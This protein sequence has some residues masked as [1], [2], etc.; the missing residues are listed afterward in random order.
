MN[1]GSRSKKLIRKSDRK[2]GM[3]DNRFEHVANAQT[4]GWVV[5]KQIKFDLGLVFFFTIRDRE[6]FIGVTIHVAKEKLCE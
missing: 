2:R 6:E 1:Y 5:R 3:F 4:V